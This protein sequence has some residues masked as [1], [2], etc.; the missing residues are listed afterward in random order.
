MA[1]KWQVLDEDG[2][3]HT[4]NDT[5][6]QHAFNAACIVAERVD[7]DCDTSKTSWSFRVRSPDGV[8]SAVFVR[9]VYEPTYIASDTTDDEARA[10]ALA[11]W[12]D[13]DDA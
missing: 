10:A 4:V 12:P 6:H 13:E 8:E 7:R 3:V 1:G 2:E 5:F 11:E 9:A